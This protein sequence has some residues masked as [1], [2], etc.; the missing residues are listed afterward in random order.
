MCKN[1][2]NNKINREKINNQYFVQLKVLVINFHPFVG[3]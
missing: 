1:S 3:F 2:F